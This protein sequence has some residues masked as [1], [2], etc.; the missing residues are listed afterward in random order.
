MYE[1]ASAICLLHKAAFL[2]S[3]L[4]LLFLLAITTA[5]CLPFNQVALKF[6]RLYF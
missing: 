6:D 2:S 3:G 5:C 1:F 4:A